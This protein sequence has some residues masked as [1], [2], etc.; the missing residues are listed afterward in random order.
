MMLMQNPPRLVAFCRTYVHPTTGVR[1][2]FHPLSNM[3]M[4][5]YLE[6]AYYGVSARADVDKVLV[7]DGH[8]P[9]VPNHPGASKRQFMRKVMPFFPLRPVIAKSAELTKFDGCVNR[10]PVESKMAFT[11]LTEA[12]NPP[13]DPRARRAIERI[14]TYPNNTSVVVPWNTQHMPY[15]Y[16]AMPLHGFEL[17]KNEEM[18]V[19]DRMTMVAFTAIPMFMFLWTFLLFVK[20][21]F[22]L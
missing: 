4:K 22:G 3:G 6:E 18:I 2:T 13:I 7:E 15:F 21:L 20:L 1:V 9:L 12:S 16:Q 17:Q 8:L 14:M 19:V 5:G 11:S 10:D